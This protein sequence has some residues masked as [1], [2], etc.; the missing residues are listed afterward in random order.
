MYL[1]LFFYN[2]FENYNFLNFVF[3]IVFFIKIRNV[4]CFC[5]CCAFVIY[6][7][8]IVFVQTILLGA[9]IND[10]DSYVHIY[11]HIYTYISGW[12]MSW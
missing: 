1:F 10:F 5:K 3:R 11:I 12:I 4:D 8:N 9:A 6:Q 7:M 2:L